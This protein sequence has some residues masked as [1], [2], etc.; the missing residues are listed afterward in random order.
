VINVIL[1]T[2]TFFW[3]LL[4][5]GFG[6]QEPFVEYSGWALLIAWLIKLGVSINTGVF[7]SGDSHHHHS[8]SDHCHHDCSDSSGGDD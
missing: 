1:G 4:L 7:F 6:W 5:L 2:F 3:A 8:G